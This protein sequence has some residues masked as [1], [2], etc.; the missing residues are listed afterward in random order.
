MIM[1][2]YGVFR[3]TLQRILDYNVVWS[4]N[5]KIMNKLKEKIGLSIIVILTAT[6]LVWWLLAEPLANRFYN[7]SVILTSIGQ[8]SALLGISLF[9]INLILSARISWMQP[10]FWGLNKIYSL[11]HKI[12]TYALVLLLI[13]PLVLAIKYLTFSWQSLW[14]FV[15]PDLNN[16]PKTYGMI[17][18]VSMFGLLAFTYWIKLRYESW[19][20]THKFLGPVF[21]LG[22]LHGF[23]IPSDIAR[24]LPLKIY[25]FVLA[26]LALAA[27]LYH[28]WLFRW[29]G[30]KFKYEVVEIVPYPPNIHE[31]ILKPLTRK[32]E[33]TAGQ[34]VFVNFLGKIIKN[35]IHP[36]S[37]S[38]SPK[39]KNLRIAIKNLGDFTARINKLEK[40]ELALIEG[41]Y[42]VFNKERGNYKEQI[43]IAG[44]VGI[45]PFLGMARDLQANDDYNITLIYAV[46]YKEEAVFMPELNEIAADNNN[47]KVF[48]HAS[49]QAGYMTVKK[50][51]EMKIDL[52][53]K[54]IFLCG[55]PP[56]MKSIGKQLAEVGV[57][58]ADIHSEEFELI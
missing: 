6:P 11:H 30:Q 21:L 46:S 1:T 27:H 58:K 34:F 20:W 3:N 35:E 16:L 56:M 33:Y 37:I 45:T 36:F 10:F 4:Q 9:A 18:L 24:F 51:K 12:G 14:Y 48:L 49:D 2:L 54:S 15:L 42:G 38:S 8:I 41:P 23:L 40:G 13:H 25:F 19:R 53:K 39:D 52:N 50:L 55:P 7:Q 47:F 57:K 44:G 43:W 5:Y 22:S 17:A 29:L 32:I 28:S 31:I 26:A